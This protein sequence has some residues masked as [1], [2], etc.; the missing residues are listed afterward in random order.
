MN[1][2]NFHVWMIQP[3]GTD[4]NLPGELGQLSYVVIPRPY[5]MYNCTGSTQ[6]LRHLTLLNELL[7]VKSFAWTLLGHFWGCWGHSCGWVDGWLGLLPMISCPGGGRALNAGSS[8]LAARALVPSS[9]RS[10]HFVLCYC[11]VAYIFFEYTI[12]PTKRGTLLNKD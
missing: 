5:C 7:L 12:M 4:R 2:H 10:S 1:V 6:I 8:R 9:L 3:P 11:Q